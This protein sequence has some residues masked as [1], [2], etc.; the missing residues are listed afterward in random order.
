MG[1]L[2]LAY[3]AMAVMTFGY[4][5]AFCESCNDSFW[6][7]SSERR[8]VVGVTAG[9]A[10]PLYWSWSAAEFLGSSRGR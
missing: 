2:F 8:A 9:L 5:A 10:W 6:Q 4:A 3:C 1:R 7:S